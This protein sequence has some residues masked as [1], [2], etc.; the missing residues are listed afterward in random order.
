MTD[1]IVVATPRV[2]VPVTPRESSSSTEEALEKRNSEFAI[3]CASNPEF[4]EEGG[5]VVDRFP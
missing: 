2:S 4:L 5:R 3:C 1:Y